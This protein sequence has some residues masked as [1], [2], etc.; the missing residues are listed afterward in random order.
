MQT[1]HCHEKVRENLH[2]NALDFP[3]LQAGMSFEQLVRMFIDPLGESSIVATAPNGEHVI[4][5]G[6]PLSR[7]TFPRCNLVHRRRN[8]N[9][10][11]QKRMLAIAERPRGAVRPSLEKTVESWLNAGRLVDAITL[12]GEKSDDYRNIVV[13]MCLRRVIKSGRDKIDAV[14]LHK[15]PTSENLLEMARNSQDNETAALLR[16]GAEWPVTPAGRG[17]LCELF[18]N[19]NMPL[20]INYL[21]DNKCIPMDLDKTFFFASL[22]TCNVRLTRYLVTK[23][24]LI[25]AYISTLSSEDERSVKTLYTISACRYMC[26]MRH[27]VIGLQRFAANFYTGGL[28]DEEFVELIRQGSLLRNFSDRLLV[29]RR[30]NLDKN[31]F[32]FI[33]HIEP[34]L[35]EFLNSRGRGRSRCDD[36]QFFRFVVSTL[37]EMIGSDQRLSLVAQGFTLPCVTSSFVA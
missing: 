23:M 28:R 9:A 13:T 20:T 34:K 8:R 3:A 29:E 14:L 12:A 1:D 26:K 22:A 25:K 6:A 30:N 11:L 31:P 36:E 35:E 37:S 10:C 33:A 17:A 21:L 27:E 15:P 7:Q 16:A 5:D 32:A 24:P 2:F 18:S 4:D 19:E